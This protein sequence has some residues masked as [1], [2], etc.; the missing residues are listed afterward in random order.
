[1]DHVPT[2]IT[3]DAMIPAVD[4]GIELFVRNKRPKDFASFS[5]ERTVLFVHGATYP[6]ST[7]FDLA[8]DGYSWMDH[9]ASRGYDVYLLDLRGYGR[10]SRPKE[11][12][13][14]AKENPPLVRG[15]TALRDISAVVDHIQDRRRL[16]RLNL[17]GWSWGTTLTGAYASMN[18]SYVARLVLYAPLWIRRPD[19]RTAAVLGAGVLPAYRS[20]TKKEALDRW[21]AGVPESARSTLIPDGWFDRWADATWATDETGGAE[22]PPVLRAPNGVI[23]DVAEYYYVGRPYYD[24]ARITA[25]TLLVV[26]EWD[27]D[28]P[29]YMA[30]MLFDLLPKS[31][32]NQ[33]V[34]L[35]EGTHSILMERNR[36]ALFSAV[37]CFLDQGST[38]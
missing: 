21:L 15:D 33:H 12:F 34:V 9:I 1:M 18:P 25:P 5:A 37:Q 38:R 24:P 14:P 28:T 3:E 20:V 11:M 30:Q 26:A 16:D 35:P 36:L 10:S 17:I 13:A 23:Q 2:L 31:P 19:A 22:R 8:L 6:G 7:A 27:N 29:P 32:A 4:P